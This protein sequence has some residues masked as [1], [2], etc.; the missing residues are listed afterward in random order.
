MCPPIWAHWRYVAN[1]VQL[2]LPS[3]F[4]SQQHKRQI[5]R[6]SRFSTAHGRKSL[7]FTIGDPFPK[8]APSHGDLDP[9]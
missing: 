1:T 3:A 2:V 6:F 9:I 4:S 7:C 5:D 8:I